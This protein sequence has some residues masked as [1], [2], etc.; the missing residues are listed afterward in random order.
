MI[1]QALAGL[2]AANN[3]PDRGKFAIAEGAPSGENQRELE[4]QRGNPPSLAAAARN[5]STNR[6]R[7]SLCMLVPF[8]AIAATAHAFSAAPG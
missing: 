1:Y 6:T 5:A 3:V 7:S 8:L 2:M 4:L